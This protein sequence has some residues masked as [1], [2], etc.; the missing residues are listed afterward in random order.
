MAY[1]LLIYA[2]QHDTGPFLGF[3][4]PQQQAAGTRS[5]PW[6]KT[7]ASDSTS[8]KS[9]GNYLSIVAMPEYAGKSFEELRWE[10]YQVCKHSHMC[11]HLTLH[12]KH[13]EFHSQRQYAC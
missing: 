8:G 11:F 12:Y 10:D 2:D 13:A 4:A 9:D 7:A 5:V 6:R 3:G 1:A